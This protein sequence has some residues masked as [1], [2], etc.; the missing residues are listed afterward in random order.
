MNGCYAEIYG[1]KNGPRMQQVGAQQQAGGQSS[2]IPTE[3]VGAQVFLFLVLTLIRTFPAM[4]GCH[5]IWVY[6]KHRPGPG[7]MWFHISCA[8]N[9]LMS[10]T[11]L[12]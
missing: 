6:D 10:N 7:L 4:G 11:P 5:R 9:F 8:H 2:V 3:I 12:S 1:E